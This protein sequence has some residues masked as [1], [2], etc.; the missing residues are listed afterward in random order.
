MAVIVITYTVTSWRGE[1]KAAVQATRRLNDLTLDIVL[2]KPSLNAWHWSSLFYYYAVFRPFFHAR[3]DHSINIHTDPRKLIRVI[4][5]L[6]IFVSCQIDTHM[7]VYDPESGEAKVSYLVGDEARF[8]KPSL[9]GKREPETLAAI[10]ISRA[11]VMSGRATLVWEVI[12]KATP[13]NTSEVS[14]LL[15]VFVFML[16]LV[17]AD[18]SRSSFIGARI[19]R[20][21]IYPRASCRRA[22]D[23]V[24]FLH[25]KIL[26]SPT[27]IYR[28]WI[29]RKTLRWNI[30]AMAWKRN[31]S[32]PRKVCE[33]VFWK[34]NIGITWKR[35]WI[36]TQN[37]LSMLTRWRW[38]LE[39]AR[40]LRTRIRVGLSD[41]SRI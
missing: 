35:R 26:S 28:A 10:S 8:F 31:I 18:S 12:R 14:L 41:I 27:R 1:T 30:Y 37:V 2:V 29:V 33:N 17:Y 19:N 4:A 22:K 25:G 5:A 11:E 15:A 38:R 39:S 20:L 36:Q 13:S 16:I 23:I 40:Q 34:T 6:S 24:K 32:F 9:E 21:R 7:K 3:L